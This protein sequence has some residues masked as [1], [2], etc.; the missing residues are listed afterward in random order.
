MS[1]PLTTPSPTPS[2][3]YARSPNEL[4][5]DIAKHLSDARDG[6]SSQALSRLGLLSHHYRQLSEEFLY[7]HCDATALPMTPFHLL[8]TFLDRPGL[9]VK[10]KSMVLSPLHVFATKHPEQE[11]ITLVTELPGF[12]VSRTSL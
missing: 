6:A 10:V 3:E 4:V 12:D 8:R 5:L 1:Q 11:T 2:E 7:E 9:A